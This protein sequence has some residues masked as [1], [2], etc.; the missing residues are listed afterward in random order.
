M[1]VRATCPSCGHGNPRENRFCGSCSVSLKGGQQ[2]RPRHPSGGVTRADTALPGRLVPVGKALTVSV[3]VLAAEAGLSW[4]RRRTEREDRSSMP[5]A[6]NASTGVPGYLV[7]QSLEEVI[8]L[9]IKGTLGVAYSRGERF[10]LSLPRSRPTGEGRT[11]TLLAPE[12]AD[13]FFDTAA[14]VSSLPLGPSNRR[15]GESRANG[16]REPRTATETAGAGKPQ[17]LVRARHPLLAV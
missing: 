15:G 4:L 5:A 7:N 3:A 9:L 1:E 2:L 12:T 17:H 8:V 6:R 11:R 10:A 14:S 13:R 16:C